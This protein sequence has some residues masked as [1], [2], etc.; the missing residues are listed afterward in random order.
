[1]LA[2]REHSKAELLQKLSQ[3]GFEASDIQLEIEKLAANELQSDKRFTENFIR[4]QT[5]RGY[6]PIRIRINLI[7]RGITEDLI[8]HFLKIS[9]N[10]WLRNAREVW[11]KRF[12]SELPKDNKMRA[13]QINFLKYR[14]FTI[15]Q[16]ENI[17]SSEI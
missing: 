17:F 4:Y 9:D 3:R 6:G 8:E 10:T 14:G 16:I 5:N 12:K 7:N 1:M 11:E 2:R 13:K 15:D